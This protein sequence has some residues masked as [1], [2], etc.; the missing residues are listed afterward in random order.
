MS[1][2]VWRPAAAKAAAVT[3]AAP[4]AA[5][6]GRDGHLSPGPPRLADV[7]V[8]GHHGRID[9]R[10]L[11]RLD[12]ASPGQR[13]ALHACAG[14]AG[15]TGPGSR[16]HRDAECVAGPY[17]PLP[18]LPG[19]PDRLGDPAVFRSEAQLCPAARAGRCLILVQKMRT[20]SRRKLHPPSGG[21]A[22]PRLFDRITVAKAPKT[23][24]GVRPTRR[25]LVNRHDRGGA[26]AMVLGTHATEGPRS[27]D[28]T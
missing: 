2:P 9:L 21:A 23:D 15:Q 18:E 17:R 8:E 22:A 28:S 10:V 19:H 20:R 12:S 11:A 3:A 1:T 14:G 16:Q 5:Y 24:Q 27:G 6:R 26:P 25:K 4:G 13:D 7:A